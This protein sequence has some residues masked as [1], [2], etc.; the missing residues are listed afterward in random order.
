MRL[1]PVSSPLSGLVFYG[2]PVPASPEN[3]PVFLDRIFY[4]ELVPTSPEN[5]PIAAH[6]FAAENKSGAWTDAPLFKP[7]RVGR[8]TC[9]GPTPRRRQLRAAARR[10]PPFAW[11][12][13]PRQSPDRR[14]SSTAA[15]C[16]ARRSQAA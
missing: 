13:G 8:Q 15:L 6:Q 14:L 3:A 7:A 10:L 5:A 11:L 9:R 1:H 4:G 12:R 16:R 2:E